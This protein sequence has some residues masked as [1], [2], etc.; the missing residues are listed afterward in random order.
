MALVASIALAAGAG[1]WLIVR[2]EANAAESNGQDREHRSG[3]KVEVVTPKQ[4]GIPR[5]CTQPGSVEPFLA[6]ALYAKVFG[7]LKTLT[8]DIGDRVEKGDLLAEI[9]IPEREAEVAKNKAK[10]DDAK[11]KLAQTEAR[12]AE[13]EAEARAAEASVKLAA[14]M[15][16]AKSAFRKYRE[17]QLG[18]IKDLVAKGAEDKRVQDEQEDYYVSALEAEN[19]AMEKVN[20][21]QERATAARVKI[22]RV[23]A[24]I[25]AAKADIE[26]A[27]AELANSEVWVRYGKIRSPFDGV[28]TQRGFLQGDF[29][30]TGEQSGNTP[31]LTVAS[32]DV[33]RVVIPVPDRDVPF[34]A[35]G[36]PAKLTF[37]ALPGETYQTAG[38]KKV[39]VS[40]LAQAEDYQTRLM[41]VEVDVQNKDGRLKQG[42][43]G[44]ATLTLTEGNKD[45][46]QIPSAAL[47]GRADD[48]NGTVRIVRDGKIQTVPVKYGTDNGIDVEI[49][50]GL[51]LQDQVVTGMN[52]P[53]NDGTPV[54]VANAGKT[55]S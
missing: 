46:L 12:K 50:S 43:Y 23:E 44:R 15:V 14:I 16:K 25:E 34:I 29:I 28:I 24:D 36:K 22:K 37:D 49:L 7:Q 11:A 55:G 42:M 1:Y 8:V 19:G 32:T 39:V 10:I 17:G 48:G 18:R 6:A 47:T 5:L 3:V 13:A 35:P 54:T 9:E 20:A 21:E 4:G 40:R 30:K 45:A 27:K 53:V 2:E 51:S 52:V 31:I 38:D 33:L 41:R 26:V